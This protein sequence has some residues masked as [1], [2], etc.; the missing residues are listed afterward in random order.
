MNNDTLSPPPPLGVPVIPGTETPITTLAEAEAFV[1]KHG[2]PVL[3]KAAFGG[4]GRGMR[5]VESMD[6]SLLVVAV[7]AAAVY[8]LTG[9]EQGGTESS[10]LSGHKAE[11]YCEM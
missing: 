8:L 11:A 9:L 10:F 3:F 4:G 5:L 6:V 7:A 2:C 1:T